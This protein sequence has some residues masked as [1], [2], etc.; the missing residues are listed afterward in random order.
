MVVLHTVGQIF[1]ACVSKLF[2]AKGHAGY[3]GP[4]CGLLKEK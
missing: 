2:M 3:C 4:V 1:K